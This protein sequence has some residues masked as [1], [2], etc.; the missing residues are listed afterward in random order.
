MKWIILI[1][2]CLVLTTVVCNVC[3]YGGK[4]SKVVSEQIDPAALLKKY[5]WF[6]DASAQLNKKVADIQVYENRQKS[7]AKNY[8]GT[9]RSEWSRE[10]REQ[11]NLWETECAGVIAS[12]N[13]L[14]AQYN[15]Q[16]SKINYRFC[17]VGDLPKGASEPL[18]REFAEYKYN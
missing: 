12:Y 1:V 11:S 5:E 9:K 13:S 6:K 10:D 7:L 17:N 15:S 18:P 16:M 8:E 4:V 14:A 3:E 2:V